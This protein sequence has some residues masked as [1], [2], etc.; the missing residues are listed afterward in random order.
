MDHADPSHRF[1]PDRPARPAWRTLLE[2]IF[3]LAVV[4]GTV[5]FALRVLDGVPGT[6]TGN[7][8]GVRHFDTIDDL[9]RA[10]GWTVPIPAFFPDVLQWPPVELRALGRTAVTVGFARRN[11]SDEWL[12]LGMAQGQNEGLP[13]Q[14]LAAGLSL[15]STPTLVDGH[16]AVLR[17]LRTADGLVWQELAW[18]RGDRQFVMRYR[19]SLAQLETMASSLPGQQP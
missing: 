17:R 13:A 15:Q 11:S 1:A 4:L 9:Q 12:L 6:V 18:H 8:R 7:P 10:I 19:G 16:P 3:S 2:S 14:L 5:A